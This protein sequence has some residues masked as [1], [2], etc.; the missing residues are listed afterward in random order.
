MTPQ[1]VTRP[2]MWD[3]LMEVAES[4]ARRSTCSRLKV[5]AV[6]SD[7]AMEEFAAGYNG[8]ERG[9]P[10]ECAS[11]EPGQCGHVHAE[12]NALVKPRSFSAALMFCT[13]APCVTCAKLI[14][15]ARVRRVYYREVYRSDAGLALLRARGVECVQL[16]RR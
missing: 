16:P 5:G 13:H 9:G 14:V 12:V 4:F 2:T 15:N 8:S 11:L 3:T 7:A 6:V 10:N 1:Q